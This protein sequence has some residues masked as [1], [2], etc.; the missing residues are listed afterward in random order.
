MIYTSEFETWWR[1]TGQFL[2]PAGDMGSQGL[3]FLK[4]FAQ[5]MYTE[6][7]KETLIKQVRDIVEDEGVRMDKKLAKIAVI[8]AD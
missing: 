3:E 2:E 1:D 5:S 6:L 7:E 4:P 8:V